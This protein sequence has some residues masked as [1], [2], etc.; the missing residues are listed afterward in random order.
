MC[1]PSDLVLRYFVSGR[2]FSPFKIDSA[3]SG[4][5]IS[6]HTQLL[7]G[8]VL[9]MDWV[10]SNCLGHWLYPTSCNVV[11]CIFCNTT[12]MIRRSTRVGDSGCCIEMVQWTF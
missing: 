11:L 3:L 7:V 12:P 5:R 6:R 8:T 1:P 9:G 10:F 4:S 2:M